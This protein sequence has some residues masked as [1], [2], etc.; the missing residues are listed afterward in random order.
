MLAFS[1]N[2]EFNR[3]IEGLKSKNK[4]MNVEKGPSYKFDLGNKRKK[5][6]FLEKLKQFGAYGAEEEKEKKQEE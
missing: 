4:K 5:D 1:N 6:L 2:S 3:G